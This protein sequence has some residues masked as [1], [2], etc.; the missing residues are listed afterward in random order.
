[1]RMHVRH[2]Q[3]G[4]KWSHGCVLRVFAG[5]GPAAEDAD[6]EAGAGAQQAVQPLQHPEDLRGFLPRRLQT[7]WPAGDAPPPFTLPST[8]PFVVFHMY[9]CLQV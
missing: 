1:M 6:A 5:Q 9:Y 7:G 4:E 2:R 3:P 8:A